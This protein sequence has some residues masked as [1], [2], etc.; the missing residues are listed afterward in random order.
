VEA[1]R[2]EDGSNAGGGRLV[3]RRPEGSGPALVLLTA[4]AGINPYF[5]RL[6]ES[7]ADHGITTLT[8]DYFARNG[9]KPDLS[10]PE[11]IMAA[12]AALPDPQ[13]MADVQAAVNH[14]REL[15]RVDPERIGVLGF[16]IGGTYSL[17]ST[18]RVDGLK[19][20]VAFYGVLR[21]GKLSD[22][23][24]VSPLEA[25]DAGRVPLLAHY[26]DED[27]LVPLH[28]VEELRERTRGEPAEVYLY[29]GAGHAFHED[30]RP[31]VYRPVAAHI[32][33]QRTLVHLDWHL[34]TG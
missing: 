26:G 4:I 16:C 1:L 6:A 27:H 7:L 28:D 33:W 23:K 22:N 2:F 11:Q 34:S 12:V 5:K 8:V 15:D 32:A 30:F 10:G 17:M 31:P 19:T 14:L 13:A 24:P 18:S 20:A 3:R 29:P 9:E 21:Y 25:V